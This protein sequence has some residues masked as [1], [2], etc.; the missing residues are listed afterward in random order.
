MPIN[1]K[2]FTDYLLKVEE[3]SKIGLKYSKD[4]YAI[5]NYTKLSELTNSFLKDEFSISLKGLNFFTR[6]IYPTPSVSVRTVIFSKDR[7]SVLLV[8]ERADGYWSLP[9]GWTELGLSPSASA[10]K[11][12]KEEAGKIVKLTHLVGVFDRYKN[13]QTTNVPEYIIVFEGEIIKDLKEF[14]FEILDV[15][16]FPLSKLPTWSIKNNPKQMEEIL[17]AAYN[18]ETIFD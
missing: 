9:G 14:C 2:D 11:E 10:I 15:Q 6:D 1:K 7:Q 13:I 4:P 16:Y 3:I 17:K 8:K 5:D 12:V 18:K